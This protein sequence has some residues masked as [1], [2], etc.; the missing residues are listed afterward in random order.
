MKST[1]DAGRPGDDDSTQVAAVTAHPDVRGERGL[2]ERSISILLGVVREQLKLEVVFIGEF[3][4]GNRVF[5]HIASKAEVSVIK[6]GEF[7]ALDATICQR[8][9]D[10]RM[11]AILHDVASVRR[12]YGL[13]RFYDSL[14]GHIGVPVRLPDGTLYGVLCG[15]SF[16]A[17][18]QL[19]ERDLRRLEMAANATARLIARAEGRD[20]EEAEA[21]R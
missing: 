12:D 4:D 10:G 2:I 16:E 21:L 14:G 9:V 15:F 11:P 6:P 18:P 13:P 1:L 3:V 5:R 8:I 7:H 17:C 19:D 20:L